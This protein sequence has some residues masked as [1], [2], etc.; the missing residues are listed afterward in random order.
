MPYFNL[1]LLSEWKRDC[2]LINVI[3][4][5]IALVHCKCSCN[6]LQAER[7]NPKSESTS[8][9]SSEQTLLMAS[10]LIITGMICNRVCVQMFVIDYI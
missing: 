6:V 1:F 8:V 5:F 2:F 9:E 10:T 3:F 7:P 4:T